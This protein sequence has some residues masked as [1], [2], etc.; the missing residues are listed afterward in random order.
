MRFYDGHLVSS[1]VEQGDVLIAIIL[2][3]HGLA[4]LNTGRVLNRLEAM[5]ICGTQ[6]ERVD[7]Y[8]GT[9]L[10]CHADE[11]S[12]E[13]VDLQMDDLVD[14]LLAELDF[15]VRKMPGDYIRPLAA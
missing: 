4:R 11:S 12:P 14:C 10:V 2:S 6:F 9:R 5:S 1:S 7:D 8:L 15:M 3:D 13:S